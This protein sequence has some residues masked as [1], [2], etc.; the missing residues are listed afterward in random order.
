MNQLPL[1][2]TQ[3][4]H[5]KENLLCLQMTTMMTRKTQEIEMVT[6]STMKADI[7]DLE[8]LRFVSAPGTPKQVRICHVLVKGK[9]SGGKVQ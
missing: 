4:S 2:I 5:Y 9:C 6:K 7:Q 8:N 3:Q 1:H